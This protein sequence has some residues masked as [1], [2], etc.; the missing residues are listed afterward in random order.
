VISEVAISEAARMRTRQ[1]RRN[2]SPPSPLAARLMQLVPV[3]VAVATAM[4]ILFLGA[5]SWALK[6]PEAAKCVTSRGG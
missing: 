6:N 1:R 5:I 4:A 2:L 3:E